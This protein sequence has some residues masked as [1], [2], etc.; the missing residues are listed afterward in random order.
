MFFRR[1]SVLPLS[2]FFFIS[3]ISLLAWGD[4]QSGVIPNW[5]QQRWQEADQAYQ[6]GDYDR[7]A[8]ITSEILGLRPGDA[9]AM[10]LE[11]K[12][13][14]KKK[15]ETNQLARQSTSQRQEERFKKEEAKK[16]AV[17]YMK[18]KKKE[19]EQRVEQQKWQEREKEGIQRNHLDRGKKLLK[20]GELQ[21]ALAEFQQVVEIDSSTPLAGLAHRFRDLVQ[22]KLEE[23]ASRK[24]EERERP[25]AKRS[26]QPRP[27]KSRELISMAWEAQ[28][29][30]QYAQAQ[31]LLQQALTIDPLNKVAQKRLEQLKAEE[32]REEI[33]KLEE[34]QLLFDQKRDLEES[35]MLLDVAKAHELP[36]EPRWK[37]EIP[38]KEKIASLDSR[39]RKKLREVVSAD[40]ED[41]ELKDVIEF[42]SRST[43]TNIILA[44]KLQEKEH[45]VT[46]RF[47]QLPLED[48]LNFL[49]KGHH[50]VY[51]VESEA[52]WMT[53]E[54]DIKD[55]PVETRIYFLNQG[56]G[57]FPKF[58]SASGGSTELGQG[59]SVS[60]VK[61][62]KD[63]LEEAIPFSGDA[64]LVTDE[65]TGAMIVSNTPANLELLE[66]LLRSLDQFPIQVLI[67]A[68]FVEINAT[69]LEELG[70]ELQMTGDMGLRKSKSVIRGDRGRLQNFVQ[71]SKGSGVNFADF[72]RGTEGLNL[73]YQGILT[74][75]EFDMVIH[76][77]QEKET[78]KTLSAPRVTTLNNQ[79]A[80]IEIVDQFIYP[81]RYEVELI[82]F[83]INGDG[84]FN[85]A[86]ET[87]FANVP[88]DF[89]T[90]DVGI[91]MKVTPSVGAEGKS[92]TLTL[93]PEVSSS[94][95]NFTFTGGV[96]I[97]KFT[98]RQLQTS[99]FVNE[100]ETIVMGGLIKEVSTTKVTKIPLLGDIPL[101]G[102]VFQRR[103]ESAE[104]R[105]L[106]IFVTPKV[107]RK[108][109][110]LAKNS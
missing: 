6:Q 71:F 46:A 31:E 4:S 68:R 82:Q 23:I 81:T 54:E 109:E 21:S 88:K 97:P 70:T 56:L 29:T 10:A 45:K 47:K 57:V 105:N 48:V 106:L 90:R 110:P 78:A 104:R 58:T 8:Q 92:M 83:D 44:K 28:K 89:V 1:G 18:E 55:E 73:T 53:S 5:L 87:E 32:Y 43:G 102:K 77:I 59:S 38:P 61:T 16:L 14:A 50:L 26:S 64:K 108:Q 80:S 93:L 42:L 107:L 40:F 35:K 103:S 3:S 12:I 15:E 49:A 36:P 27:V 39:T 96:T 91:I 72:S 17:Q 98:S 94:S 75:P 2:L 11:W 95:G 51:R 63:I 99:V 86:G 67:E 41:V 69:D 60:E 25:K 24:R 9:D 79:T 30:K 101:L 33:R 34:E 37:K 62:I 85:D 52:V 65:R 100:G 20:K 22:K 7:A 66:K 84:D 74:Y 76:A 13:I 19:E